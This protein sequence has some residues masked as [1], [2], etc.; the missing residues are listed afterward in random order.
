[1]KMP[2]LDE[3]NI[4]RVN[5]DLYALAPSGNLIKIN[6][7]SHFGEVTVLPGEKFMTIDNV[8]YRIDPAG[9]LIRLGERVQP[10]KDGWVS[11]A[12]D[13]T[14]CVTHPYYQ[15]PKLVRLDIDSIED[16]EKLKNPSLFNDTDENAVQEKTQEEKFEEVVTKM[17]E[18]YR[19]K[20]SD[21]GNSVQDTYD[22]IGD[23]S[24]LTRILDK[25][26]RLTT[27]C[28]PGAVRKVQDEKI[29]DTLLD[30]A[31]YAVLFLITRK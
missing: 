29:E 7:L 13:S 24:F 23:S 1:M 2:W 5:G 14:E 27:L 9:N 11:L 10:S 4:I 20:N 21:Y 18:V 30:L 15:E 6:S 19:A 26:N 28:Q 31:N 22:K 8:D 3:D 25:V 16:F 12:D 17:L